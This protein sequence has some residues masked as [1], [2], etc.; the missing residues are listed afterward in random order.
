MGSIIHILIHTQTALCSYYA[1]LCF[2]MLIML[3]L[4]SLCFMLRPCDYA[5][6]DASIIR[7]PQPPSPHSS[8]SCGTRARAAGHAYCSIAPGACTFSEPARRPAGSG[9]ALPVACTGPT[10]TEHALARQVAVQRLHSGEKWTL[11]RRKNRHAGRV[12]L[13]RGAVQRGEASSRCCSDSRARRAAGQA[14]RT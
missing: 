7:S 6:F 13:S 2:I 4:C 11:A 10:A 14:D 8:A 1:R 3:I 5:I 9:L 12:D